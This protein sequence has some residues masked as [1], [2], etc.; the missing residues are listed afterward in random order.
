VPAPHFYLD[1]VRKRKVAPVFTTELT[2]GRLIRAISTDSDLFVQLIIDL[3][4]TNE[5]NVTPNHWHIDLRYNDSRIGSDGPVRRSGFPALTLRYLDAHH[6]NNTPVLP[7]QSRCVSEIVGLFL[8]TSDHDCDSVPV[9]I[10]ALLS[11]ENTLSA[12][13][14]TESHVGEWSSLDISKLHNI[15]TA[16]EV[17]RFIPEITSAEQDGSLGGGINSSGFSIE[18]FDEPDDHARF[19]GVIE[20]TTDQLFKGFKIVVAFF[21]ENDNPTGQTACDVGYLP[22][23]VRRHWNGWIVAAE[24]WA[25]KSARLFYYDKKWIER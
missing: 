8:S 1:A 15:V 23:G 18:G 9:A 22:P 19:S 4:V 21:D 3:T 20:N 5:G 7:G 25:A 24:I 2:G 17:R 13:V 11:P 6:I 16:D 14:V 10:N 12:S